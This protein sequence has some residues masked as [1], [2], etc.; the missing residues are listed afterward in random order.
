MNRLSSPGSVKSVCA[1]AA[2]VGPSIVGVGTARALDAAFAWV[3]VPLAF[4]ISVIFAQ[5]L[6]ARSE[7]DHEVIN[8]SWFI[9]PVVNIVVPMTLLPLIPGSSPATARLLLLA[10]YGFWGM[11]FFLFVVVLATLHHRLVNH[12]LPHAGLASTLWIPLGP[13]GVGALTLM[14]MADASGA[15]FGAS[16]SSIQQLSLV[17]ASAM[18]GFGIWW[19]TIAIATLVRYLSQ[20]PLPY[21]PGW[22]AFIFPLGAFTV[23]DLSVAR[24][25][26]TGL[27][28][29]FGFGLFVLLVLSWLVVA[30]TSV[31]FV[32]AKGRRHD[33]AP[34]S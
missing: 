21:G 2:L 34:R 14:K 8:G 22:W 29:W 27:I 12:P 7:I 15:V 30:V 33:A 23:A 5:L 20:G 11:G 16:G 24:A 9:P 10:S 26:Q 13:L 19:L 6:F 4:A 31:K 32:V 1:A 28:E 3:G 17:A 18:W 25:W